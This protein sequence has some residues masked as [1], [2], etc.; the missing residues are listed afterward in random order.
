VIAS[1]PQQSSFMLAL[2]N[3]ALYL[4]ASVGSAL[5]GGVIWAASLGAVPPVSAVIAG[6]ALLWRRAA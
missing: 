3:S 2:N 6:L 1:N 5:E 4:G